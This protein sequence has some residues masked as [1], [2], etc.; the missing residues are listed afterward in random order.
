MTEVSQRA[1]RAVALQ[2]AASPEQLDHLVSITRPSDWILT[3]VICLAL[4]AA[5]TWGV[6][7]RIPTRAAGEGILVSGG[8]RVVD[9]V[10]AAAGRLSSINVSV[11]DHVRQGQ[12]I[13]QI[14][15]TDISNA[16]PA[17]SRCFTNANASMPT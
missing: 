16:T 3:F 7:G 1:F 4:A 14:A 5:L 11:G 13:A 2:R 6:V 12:P 15:Q 8:G 9:A 17:P 10:S